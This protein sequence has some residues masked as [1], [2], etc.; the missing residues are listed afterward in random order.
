MLDAPGGRDFAWKAGEPA[1]NVSRTDVMGYLTA[2]KVPGS[3]DHRP[4]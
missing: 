1:A 4:I 2:G 3:A